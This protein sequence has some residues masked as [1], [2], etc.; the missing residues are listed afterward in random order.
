MDGAEIQ[1]WEGVASAVHNETGLEAPIDAFDL[2]DHCG[3]R[4]EP[5]PRGTASLDGD[6]I[7]YDVSARPVRQHG[8][9]AHETAHHVLRLHAEPDPEPAAR[10]VAGAL[11]LP[12]ATFD[13]DL[14]ET[15]WDL[16]RLRAKHLNCSAEMI[17]RRI[18]ELRDAVVTVLDNG[19]VRTRVYSPWIA[20]WAGAPRLLRLSR[21]ERELVD[22]ALET[23]EVQ[24]E[25]ELL[26]A[27]PVFDGVHRRVIVV[28]E[29]K[30][31]SLRI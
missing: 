22:A 30:Q 26:A 20:E 11:M 27:Y 2:A 31:L 28:A 5:G 4:I 9:V 14:R 17:A 13:R 15:A 25:G 10:Y 18:V 19:K 29:A 24:R 23:G 21:V 8:M 1:A 6:V 12:R 16:E 3:L 7:R